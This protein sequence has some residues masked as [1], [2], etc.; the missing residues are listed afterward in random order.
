MSPTLHG[1]SLCL[2]GAWGQIVEWLGF[3]V[4]RWIVGSADLL[5]PRLWADRPDTAHRCFDYL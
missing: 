2:L 3:S 5:P 1:G 4:Y